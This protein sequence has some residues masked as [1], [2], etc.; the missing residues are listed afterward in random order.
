MTPADRRRR[1]QRARLYLCTPLRADLEDF[2]DT[3]LDGGVDIVQLRDK[4]AS[5]DQQRKAAGLF[6]AA[7]E[8]HHAL[9]VVNDDP[10]LAR[11]CGADGVHVG[12]DDMP[13]QQVRELVG[14]DL[15]I[16]RSTHGTSQIDQAQ[17]EPCDYFAVGPVQA[18]PTK[19]GRPGIGLEP[20]RHAAQV[21][22]KP[23]FVTGGMTAGTAGPV[24]AAGARRLV[25]VRALTDA[26]DPGAAAAGLSELL[27]DRAKSSAG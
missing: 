7:C 8:R 9:F 22:T 12:Q 27:A 2:L 11:Q 4:T 23:W 6:T 14:D 5:P 19:Q 26:A 13:P 16:G 3:V 18:T 10:A 21:A 24:L 17:I 1:L 25:V 20:L 15:L